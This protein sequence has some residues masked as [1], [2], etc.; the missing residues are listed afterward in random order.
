MKKSFIIL[1]IAI[2]YSVA[3]AIGVEPLSKELSVKNGEKIEETIK[4]DPE[5][6]D[7]NIKLELYE[8]IQASN[9]EF[10]FIKKPDDLMPYSSWIDFPK[11]ALISAGQKTLIPVKFNIPINA[12]AGTYNFVIMI[13]PQENL[14]PTQIGIIMRYAIRFT[15]NVGGIGYKKMDLSAI[16]ISPDT[17][18]KPTILA[19]LT[20]TS[21]FD[22]KTSINAIL[23]DDN[24]KI[25][26]KLPLKSSYMDKNDK[27]YQKILQ[28]NS[29]YFYGQPKYLLS[30]G[31]YKI[32]LF[33]SYDDKQKI[34]TSNINIPDNIFKFASGE[35]LSLRLDQ[36]LYTYKMFPGTSKTTVVNTENMS[37][38][39]TI[40][41]AT[42]KD[43]GGLSIDRS[44]NQW[45][46]I[47]GQNP[48]ELRNKRKSRVIVTLKTTK[49]ASPG[50]Y[51]GKIELDSFNKETG[52]YLT[53]EDVSLEIL[54]GEATR[55]ATISGFTYVNLEDNGSVS[56]KVENI[57]DRFILP[58]AT[59][60]IQNSE[61]VL[62]ASF[63][64]LPIEENKW[65]LPN[66]YMILTGD[67]PKLEP[68]EYFY[69]ISL[70]HDNK[71]LENIGG[72]LNV[73]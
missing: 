15:L 36:N 7:K 63:D 37:N 40:V 22:L 12:K 44:I 25:I 5:L 50:A 52:K 73:E 69:N 9:G 30:S 65:L 46:E 20:N 8:L 56:F 49:E 3:F 23:R 27:N 29:I 4:I 21:D 17:N 61:R 51:Y 72:V 18:K 58:K 47:K 16:E 39:D 24:G 34:Y 55:E 62:V 57:G 38:Y 66:D 10:N 14:D 32:N 35:E 45:V 6:S 1:I 59:I 41:R 68:G 31:N 11:E 71:G 43:F 53:S 60:N 28:G 13:T 70:K 42:Y 54:I 26:E 64:A 48:F 67:T 33:V 19:T 2:I